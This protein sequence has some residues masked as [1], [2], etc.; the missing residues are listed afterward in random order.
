MPPRDDPPSSPSR[1]ADLPAADRERLLVEAD[2]LF[3]GTREERAR[4]TATYQRLE[5]WLDPRRAIDISRID[6]LIVGDAPALEPLLRRVIAHTPSTALGEKALVALGAVLDR[7]GRAE[8]AERTYREALGRLAGRGDENEL[9]AT[10]NLARYFRMADRHPEALLAAR[11]AEALAH[12]RVNGWGVGLTRSYV[13]GSLTSLEDWPRAA[14]AVLRLSSVL[15]DAPEA[16]RPLLSIGFHGYRSLLRLRDGDA[17]GALDD[18]D[19]MAA[20]ASKTHAVPAVGRWAHLRRARALDALSR[21]GEAAAAL[22]RAR[23]EVSLPDSFFVEVEA[24]AIE[25]LVARGAH[26]AAVEAALSLA[27]AI[28]N[29]GPALGTGTRL[30]AA[31]RLGR[32]LGGVPGGERAARRAYGVAGAA[33]VVRIGEVDRALA[34]FPG[35]GDPSA[36]DLAILDDH[37]HRMRTEQD[38]VLDAVVR[39]LVPAIRAG[40]ASLADLVSPGDYVAVCAWCRRVRV[41]GDRWLPIHSYVPERAPFQFTHGICPACRDRVFAGW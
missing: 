31:A 3:S 34:G 38:E 27:T 41:A 20:A 8:E 19:A 24:C 2:A 7:A 32:L 35:L 29:A 39:L 25:R 16:R 17:V 37:R 26:P 12:A 14:A 30:V 21:D 18:A 15:G 9:A 23:G 40:E 28:E 6:A 4:A 1:G 5:V 33:A 13:C 10:I 22:D 36:E 11:R